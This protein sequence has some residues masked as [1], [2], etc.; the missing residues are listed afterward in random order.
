MEVFARHT[1]PWAGTNRFRLMPD[2]PPAESAATAEVVIRAG[3]NLAVLSYTWR[4]PVDGSQDGLLVLGQG[5]QDGSVVAFW[6][7]SWHQKP[8]AAALAGERRDDSITV[9]Y[10]YAEGWEWRI[11]IDLASPDT[12]SLR[13]DNVVPASAAAGAGAPITYWAMAADLRRA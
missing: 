3:G 1:G 11:T 9:G 12:L 7:D 8:G 13:M 2:D 10:S 5:A 6:G 4:H